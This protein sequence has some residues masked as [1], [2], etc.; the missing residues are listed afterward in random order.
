MTR[1]NG[2]LVVVGIALLAAVFFLS[3]INWGLPSRSADRFLFGDRPP[4]TGEQ[5]ISLAGGWDNSADRGADIA[6]HPLAGRDQPIVLNE[7]DAQRA[8]IVR[9]FR[10]YSCQ[11]D[12]MIT[13]RSLSRMKPS[14]GDLDPR[15]YQYGGLWVYVIGALLKIASLFHFV[16]LRTDLAYY[17]DHPEQFARFYIVA[18]LYAAAWGVLG[19]LVVY[20]LAV[21][22][23]GKS[24]A[25]ITAALLYATMPVVVNMA[26][27]A[28]PHLPGAVLTLA[29]V[30]AAMRYVCVGSLRWWIVSGALCG[31]AFGMVLTGIVAFAIIPVMVLLRPMSWRRRVSV[32]LAAGAV[33]VAVFVAT[34]PYLPLNYLLHRSV[35]RS[36]VGNYGNFYKPEL[37]LPALTNAVRLIGQGMS[38]PL[39]MV[40]AISLCVLAIKATKAHDPAVGCGAENRLTAEPWALGPLFIAP[41]ALV[42]LQF[43]LLARDKPAEYARFALTLDVMLAIATAKALSMLTP[44]AARGA[45]VML[46]ALSAVAGGKY[47]AH[48][49]GDHGDQS[50]R[51]RAAI[52]L[53]RQSRPG[54][55]L[56]VLAEPAPYCL[57][58]VNLFDWRIVLLPRGGDPSQL[59]SSDWASVWPQDVSS[60]APISWANKPMRIDFKP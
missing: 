1:T 11:P 38:L 16:T 46:L 26:H 53:Q 9:R 50:T 14:R 54:R 36:N 25:A 58:P 21:E 20:A 41:A 15:F 2:R 45:A 10:L 27:E 37:S 8:E 44:T 59:P 39:A 24:I 29:A 51:L 60:D 7:T 6:M 49:R 42:A 55:T 4:W 19:V 57:P 43:V 23:T 56:A 31:A 34:N 32:M 22:W 40:A 30:W 35:V 48:F 18:R 13:F 47:V 52:E 3:G 28:K 5:I 12:E 17:L 33:G